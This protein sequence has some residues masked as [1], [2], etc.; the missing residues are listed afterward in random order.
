MS[1]KQKPIYKK[2]K[3]VNKT[4]LSTIK[5]IISVACVAILSIIVYVVAKNGWQYIIDWFKGKWFCFV[6]VIAL[7]VITIGWNLYSVFKFAIKGM[8]GDEK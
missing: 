6:V 2:K 8:S 3:A 1:N 7:F 4:T 5:I